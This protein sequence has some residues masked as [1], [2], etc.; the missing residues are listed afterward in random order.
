MQAETEH[1]SKHHRHAHRKRMAR[2]YLIGILALIC[3][4]DVLLFWFTF[5]QHNPWRIMVGLMFGQV[6]GSI[7]LL[8]GIWQR[9]PWARYVLAVLNF[10]VIAIFAMQALYL[11]GRPEVGDQR[12]LSLI[13]IAVGLLTIAN[14]WLIRSKRIQY[15]A[16]QPGSGGWRA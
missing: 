5:S 15:L 16:T 12:M 2:I 7:L 1:Q 8:G 14:T 9:N 4:A 11:N 13:W 3:T 10:G 6:I